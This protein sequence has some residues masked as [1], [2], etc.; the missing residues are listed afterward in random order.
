MRQQCDHAHTEL[1][2][3]CQALKELLNSIQKAIHEA[4]FPSAE[5]RDEALYLYQH[6]T[7]A[8]RLWKCHQ[9]R[10]VRQD[11]A[12]LDVLDRLDEKSCLVTNDWAMK[13][14]PQRY[15]ETQSDWFGKRGI[16][17]HIS[18]VARRVSG[19]L[20]TQTFVHILQSSNQGSSTV[21]LLLEHV[22]RTL[23]TEHPEIQRAYFRQDNA[24]CYHSA[25]TV[26]AIPAIQ[27]SSGVSVLAVDFSD[28]QGGKGPADRMSATCK[29]H[30][31]RHINE[32]H[33]VTSAP[34]MRD[35]ILS[36]GGVGGV[37]V[38]VVEAAI[39]DTPDHKKIPGIN[40]LNN[41]EYQGDII[42][43]RRAYGIGEGSQIMTNEGLRGTSCRFAFLLSLRNVQFL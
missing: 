6:A 31:R 18:V 36:H 8:I 10:T 38:A 16:S 22:L 29:N 40:K 24:G 19:Q 14:L 1:C 5:E 27:S 15:R 43:A 7:E 21:I 33:D 39:P 25:T 23:K 42:V 32:G 34:Q 13:F 2:D 9:I 20:Q 41:F 3:Q 30:I 11:Q 35:A 28:P 17:W 4:D 26:L 37:R 12:R